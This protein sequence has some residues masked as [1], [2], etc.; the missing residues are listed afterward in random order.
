MRLRKLVA[1]SAAARTAVVAFWRK[2]DKNSKCKEGAQA[3]VRSR[4]RA[5]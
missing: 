4:T 5:D 1:R 3:R 2:R